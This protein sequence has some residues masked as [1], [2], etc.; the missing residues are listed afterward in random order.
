[1]LTTEELQEYI[2]K[3]L[4]AL[5]YLVGISDDAGLGPLCCIFSIITASFV[6]SPEEIERLHKSLHR[7]CDELIERRGNLPIPE[8][9]RLGIE[10]ERTGKD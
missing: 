3:T 10:I 2:D 5:V 4:R 7:Y 1:M 8:L 6:S 9:E